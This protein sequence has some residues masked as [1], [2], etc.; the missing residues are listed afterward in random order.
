MSMH[1]QHARLVDH[2]RSTTRGY[3]A[4]WCRF[5]ARMI[6]APEPGADIPARKRKLRAAARREFQA[7]VDALYRSDI[8]LDPLYRTD[9]PE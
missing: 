3:E 7:E 6:S 8:P 9:G 4:A 1:E 2:V 5:Y